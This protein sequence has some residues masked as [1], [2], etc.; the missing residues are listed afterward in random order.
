MIPET[1]E[2]IQQTQ[3]DFQGHPFLVSMRPGTYPLSFAKKLVATQLGYN[4]EFVIALT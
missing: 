4:L 2:Q 3:K 1:K